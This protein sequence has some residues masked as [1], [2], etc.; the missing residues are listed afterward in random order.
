[1]L[2]VWFAVRSPD[3]D[4]D[5]KKETITLNNSNG[6]AIEV[7]VEIADEEDER[8]EG[9]MHRESLC[10]DCGML[11]VYE[12]SEHRSFWMKNTHIPLSIAFIS[13]NGTIM[14]IQQMEPETTESHVSEDPCRY[15]LEVNQGFFQENHIKAGDTV[16]IPERFQ[17]G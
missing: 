15:A 14:E 11:F 16:S 2:L 8:T 7:K 3:N 17:D 4:D 13:E 1:M 6:E 5:L 10:E 9:L 12:E